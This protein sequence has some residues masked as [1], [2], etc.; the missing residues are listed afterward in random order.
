MYIHVHSW[1]IVPIYRTKVHDFLIQ[2]SS[3][4]N[5]TVEIQTPIEPP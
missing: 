1:I 5:P 4:R 2:Y 3:I